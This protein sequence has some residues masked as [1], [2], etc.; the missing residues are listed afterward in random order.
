MNKL[1]VNTKKT[2]FM[3][4]TNRN[5]DIG[6]MNIKLAGSEIKHVLSLQFLG[7]TIHN[8]LT[9]KNHLDIICNQL[10]KNVGVLYRIKMLPTN[11]LRMIYNAI[12]AP[13]LD[14]GIS[15]WG[16]AAK[17][18]L[19]RLFKLQKRAIRIVNH[20]P[21][22]AHTSPIFYSLKLLNIYD[23]YKYQLGIFMFLCHRKLLPISLLKYYTLN[24]NIHSHVTR[25]AANFH[26]PKVRTT[27]SYKS[28]IYQGPLVWN[29]LPIYIRN[30]KTLNSFKTKYKQNL[31]DKYNK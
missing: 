19:E 3:M 29:T 16:S 7:V 14:Y 20:S 17:I 13:F 25:N 15:V 11:V 2:N 10:S 28:V 31:Q 6:Q 5:I 24:C 23:I 26:I 21:Y 30:S 4:F 12:V 27:L 9:W 1:T 18:Y 8:K 22:L